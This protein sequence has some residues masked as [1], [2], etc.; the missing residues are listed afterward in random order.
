MV[1]VSL[2]LITL[3]VMG[4]RGAVFIT[5]SNNM[6]F[7]NKRHKD[8]YLRKMSKIKKIKDYRDKMSKGMEKNRLERISNLNRMLSKGNITQE[9][10]DSKIK[11]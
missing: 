7:K 9:Y 10:Y 6:I 8:N 2:S 4:G 1:T 3:N 5:Q 11:G